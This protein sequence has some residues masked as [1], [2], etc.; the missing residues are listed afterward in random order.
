VR[1]FLMILLSAF[2]AF[3]QKPMIFPGGVVNAASFTPATRP[4]VPNGVVPGAIVSIFGRNLA[5]RTETAAG[6]P[7][8]TVLGGTSVTV[9][10]WP[11]HILR[12]PGGLPEP[13]NAN[14]HPQGWRSLCRSPVR[15]LWATS[16][17]KDGRRR[18]PG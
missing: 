13:A 14:Q 4:R 12:L 17:A 5:L 1:S 11:A 7:L 18:R 10:G 9:G 8:P 15:Q 6:T 2:A 3:G 16:V